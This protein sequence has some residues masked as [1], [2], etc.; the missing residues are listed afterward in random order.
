MIQETLCNNQDNIDSLSSRWPGLSFWSPAVGRQGGVVILVNQNFEGEIVSWRKDTDGRIVSL[1]VKIDNFKINLICIYAPTNLTDRKLFFETLHEFFLPA[2][3]TILGGDFNCYERELDKF[4][5]NASL[6]NYLTDFRLAFSFEDI[7]RKLHPKSRDV[8]WFNSN[9]TI[10][11][12]LDKFFVTRNLVEKITACDLSPCCFSDHDFLCLHANLVNVEPRGPGLWKFNNSFLTNSTFCDLISKRISDLSNCVQ[13]F[14]S[15]RAWWDFFKESLKSECI[16]FA[17]NKRKSTCRERVFL[18][19][20]LIELKQRLV[21]GDTFCSLEIATLQSRL[22]ALILADLEGAKTRSK[23]QFLEKGEKPTRFFFKLERERFEKN[24]VTSI[25][26]DNDT[27]VFSRADVERAHVQFYTKLFSE[28]PIDPVCKQQCFDHFSKTLPDFEQNFC[29]EQISLAELTNSV[30]SL[31]LNKSPGPDGLTAEFFIHF[32]DLLG[33]IFLKI[34]ETCLA[35]GQLCESMK[36][37]ATRLIYKKR[38]EIND[39]KNWRPISLLNVD[40]KILSKVITSR[41][42]RVLHIIIDSDQTCSIPGRSIFSNVFLIRDVL[43][44]IDLTNETALLVSLDQEKAFDRVNRSFL[45]DLLKHL[46]FGP[47]FC[48]WID[49]LYNGAY[50]QIIL[51]GYLTEKI[52]L[53]RGVRQGDPLSPLLYVICVE[54]LACLIRDTAGIEGF[55]LPGAKGKRAKTRLYADDTTVILKD[56]TSLRN[57]F[58]VISIYEAGSGAKLNKSKTEAMW[59]GAWKNRSDEP[60]GLTW[61][62]K[63]KILGVFFGTVPVEQDNWQP[64]LNKLEKSLNLWKSRSL[65]FIGKSL[66]VN[67]LGLSKFIYLAK[68]LIMPKWVLSRINQLIW[69]FIWGTRMETVSRNTCF[70]SPVSGGINICNLKIKAEALKL[71]S[72]VVTIDSPEDSSFFL[73]KYFVGRRLSTLRKKWSGLRDNS[74]PSAA[75]LTPYYDRCLHTLAEIDEKTE[76]TSKK[77]Y[78]KLLSMASSPPLLPGGWVP[79]LRVDFSIKEHWTLVRDNFCENFKNDI[80]WLITLRGIKVRDSLRTWGYIDNARCASCTRA[81]T[82]DHCFLNCVR[83]KRVWDHFAPVLAQLLGITFLVNLS[84]VYFF[85]WPPVPDQRARI[86]RYVIKS[87]LYGIWVFRNKATFHNGREDHRA[88]IRYIS[89]DIRRRVKLDMVRFSEAQFARIWLVPSFC[90]I[91]DGHPNILI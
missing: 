71:A 90:V 49:I 74:A 83:A 2:D 37:S 84:F 40:Y 64:K 54:A 68:T 39:L 53:R 21:Q 25:L 28:E 5:G 69:P 62:R 13:Q 15:V 12:R 31:N 7:W 24:T 32:W 76:L 19:N 1:L 59:L 88:I 80:L 9:F 30:K 58:K 41:L 75:S 66:I 50:M 27:L 48:K 61:V 38:G 78:V 34:V 60:L 65:S 72:L 22:K 8:S 73:A 17:K 85:K 36:G 63:M 26:N 42:S 81:E 91:V 4:G 89:D 87:I 6:A 3:A 33:P 10:G 35:E 14:N 51:N 11:S 18:T 82:I 55:L 47:N 46:G 52:S 79:F 44:Y 57:L 77:I 67:V 29:D 56:F 23:V 86:C 20:R 16:F 45:T 70:L 43:D